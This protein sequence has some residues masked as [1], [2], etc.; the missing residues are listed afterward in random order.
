MTDKGRYD[1]SGLTEAQ[2]EPGS[3]GEVLKNRL[4][5]KNSVEMDQVEA[6]ALAI[7]TDAF[8]KSYRELPSFFLGVLS[9][10]FRDCVTDA[11]EVAVSIAVELETLQFVTLYRDVIDLNKETPEC[12]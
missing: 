8:Y 9:A 4:G 6:K 12:P 3:N 2:F 1:V 5:I 10:S 7:A 11:V